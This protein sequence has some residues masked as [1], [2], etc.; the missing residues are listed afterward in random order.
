[1]ELGKRDNYITVTRP[2]VSE[3]AY[4]DLTTTSSEAIASFWGYVKEMK[5]KESDLTFDNGRARFTRTIKI[6]ADS[7]DTVNVDIDDHLTLGSSEFNWEVTNIFEGDWKWS[8]TIIA[9]I[10]A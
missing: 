8:R 9:Q 5:P 4:G 7:R 10:K 1:M 6:M 3:D 2:V